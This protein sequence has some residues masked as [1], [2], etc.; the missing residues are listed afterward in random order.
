MI[1]CCAV[2]SSIHCREI[3]VRIASIDVQALRSAST[4]EPFADFSPSASLPTVRITAAITVTIQPTPGCS[5]VAMFLRRQTASKSNA[6]ATSFGSV[7]DLGEARFTV[8]SS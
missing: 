5:A 8:I 6:V 4:P 1:G 3:S 7:E 2:K